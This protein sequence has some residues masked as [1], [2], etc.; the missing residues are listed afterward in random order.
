MDPRTSSTQFFQN[1]IQKKNIR[2]F[3]IY[4]GV[5]LLMV[6]LLTFLLRNTIVSFYLRKKIVHF[7]EQYHAELTVKQAKVRNLTSILISNIILKPEKGDTLIEIDSAYATVNFWKLLRGRFQLN[8]LQLRKTSITFIRHDSVNNY[9]WLLERRSKKGIEDTT[10]TTINIASKAN[11]FF[12]GVFDRIP[13]SLRID[14]FTISSSTNGHQVIM[15]TY[16]WQTQDHQFS[17]TIRVTENGSDAEWLTIGRIDNEERII[18]FKL[19]PKESK[20]VILPYILYRWNSEIGFDTLSF[21]LSEGNPGSDMTVVNGSATLRGL[22]IRDDRL[23]ANRVL[24]D[25]LGFDY[26]VNFG[27]DFAE[28]DSS[29]LV[30]F[31]A[32]D[33]HP[34]VKYRP[35]PTKQITLKLHKPEFPAE[36]IFSSIPEGLFTYVRD[37]RVKG[38]LSYTLDFFVD[39]SDPDSLLFESDLKRRQ[40]SV[41]SY[42]TA[43]LARINQPFLYTAYEK[44]VPVA[45]FMVGPENPNFRTLDHISPYLK[46]SVLCSEDGGFYLHRGFSE[47]A[48]RNSIIAN[49]NERRFVRGGSTI[50]MQLVKN[51]FLRRNKTIGRKA[52]EALIVWLLENQGITSKDRMYEVYLNIIEWGPKIYGANEA[53][54]FYF[55]K[56]AS[57][58]TLTESIFLASVIPKPKWFKY[59]FDE[60]GHLRESNAGFYTLL[61][62]KMLKKGQITKEDVDKLIPD[63]ELKGPAKLLLKRADSIPQAEQ[64][65][66][67]EW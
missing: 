10:T 50:T 3:V 23:A 62:E 22:E 38:N 66:T 8:E 65:N 67:T 40:F 51:V 35:K 53:A 9:M 6:L 58:L 21:S 45:A 43:D 29:S 31:N 30:T 54:R 39:L 16:H 13:G 64:E 34:Y 12:R 55:N 5:G 14:N 27:K 33:I 57:K 20:K 46:A 26:T 18:S 2:R 60:S 17:S 4:P 28:L 47:E 52:E 42:G 41:L 48:F 25:K 11:T 59:S 1:F 32:L 24:F 61:S 63:V 7:N 37:M 49:I 56:D 44:G 36:E 15:H 19:Y